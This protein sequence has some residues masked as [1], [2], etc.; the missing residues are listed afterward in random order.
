MV[1][2]VKI[3][4][5]KATSLKLRNGSG[6]HAMRGADFSGQNHSLYRGVLE[7]PNRDSAKKLLIVL[8]A[9]HLN[10]T[11][12]LLQNIRNFET[13]LRIGFHT[14]ENSSTVTKRSVTSTRQPCFKNKGALKSPITR[15]THSGVSSSTM[16]NNKAK[17][18][19]NRLWTG[20]RFCPFNEVILP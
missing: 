4:K 16:F 5:S 12:P 15:P 13:H 8:P 7:T 2:V 11:L 14:D 9:A 1:G 18:L 3:M 10:M 17:W 6:F 19:T 20:Y